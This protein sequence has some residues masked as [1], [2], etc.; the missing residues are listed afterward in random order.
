MHRSYF[1]PVAVVTALRQD[2]PDVV[3]PTQYFLIV[4]F[5]NLSLNTYHGIIRPM[6]VQ[7]LR[8]TRNPTVGSVMASQARPTN[9]MMEA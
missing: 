8:L 1:N 3:L 7:L 5:V 6:R 2:S 4:S 9:R